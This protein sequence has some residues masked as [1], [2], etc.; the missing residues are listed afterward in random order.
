MARRSG[1]RIGYHELQRLIAVEAGVELERLDRDAVAGFF[2]GVLQA[3]QVLR[4]AID[5]R[6][7]DIEYQSFEHPVSLRVADTRLNKETE[8]LKFHRAGNIGA[9]G[10]PS[11]CR[12]SPVII[13]KEAI[14]TKPGVSLK[15]L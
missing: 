3:A 14:R 7:L 5:E 8:P 11:V 6:A 13:P 12:L 4:D 15:C 9:S 2:Q 1:P 10:V